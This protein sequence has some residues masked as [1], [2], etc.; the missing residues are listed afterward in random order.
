MVLGVFETQQH[1]TFVF[2]QPYTVQTIAE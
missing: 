1:F 2:I